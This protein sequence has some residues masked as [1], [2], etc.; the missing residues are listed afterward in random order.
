LLTEQKTLKIIELIEELRRDSPEVDDR[1]DPEAER[2]ATKADPHAVL[3]I[4]EEVTQERAIA[5]TVSEE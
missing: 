1:I 3:G 2:M 5:S 4:I